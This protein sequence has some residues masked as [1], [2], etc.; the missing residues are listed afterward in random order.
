MPRATPFPALPG[1]GEP[2]W[3]D[4]PGEHVEV[5]GRR[6]FVRRAGTPGGEP[7][8]FVH[9]LGGASTNW[10]DLMGLL[11]DR[12]DG[13]APD[14]PGFGWSDPPANGRYGLDTHADAVVAY[15]ESL[16]TPVH[17]LGNS[18]GGAV[19]IRVAAE[20]P[21]LVRTLTLVSPALP[22]YRLRRDND[23]RLALL[24]VPGLS[25]LVNRERARSGAYK[26]VL[27]VLTLCTYDV[28]VIPEERV[29]AAVVEVRRRR[30]LPHGTVSLTA[31]LRGLVRSYF[32]PGPRNLWRQLGCVD[33]PALVVW[34][35]HDRLVP[36]T[37]APVAVR[38]L[39]HGRLL[40]LRDAGHVAQMERP[41]VV[42]DAVRRLLDDAEGLRASA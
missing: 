41:E 18:L 40:T 10:T 1:P 25:G 23:P 36:R 39:R 6:L 9:G 2:P 42:A 20:H 8:V 13:H 37:L 26:V 22:Q 21:H 27:D 28:S 17:L 24:L 38:R 4:W 19:S 12:L 30:R 29:E 16:G 14:L 33:A 15:I 31:S 11:G 35:D 3:P 7:A 5:G 34:G 32:E